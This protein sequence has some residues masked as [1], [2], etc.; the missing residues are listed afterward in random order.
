MSFILYTEKKEIRFLQ[1]FRIKLHLNQTFRAAIHS[2]SA[3]R[4]ISKAF[5]N[6]NQKALDPIATCV[7]LVHLH[8]ESML[9]GNHTGTVHL[10]ALILTAQLLPFTT[11]EGKA[12]CVDH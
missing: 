5:R 12:V 1:F 4:E 6:P 10:F 8:R 9:K 3:C 2:E 7:A 11:K